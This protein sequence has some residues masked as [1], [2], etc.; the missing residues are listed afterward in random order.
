MT[1]RLWFGQTTRSSCFGVSAGLLS[2]RAEPV[3]AR[4]PFDDAQGER[5]LVYGATI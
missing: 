2:V 1:W 4:E 3:E 5:E